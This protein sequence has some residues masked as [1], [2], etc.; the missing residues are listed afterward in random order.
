[1]FELM[2]KQ[3]KQIVN[4][5]KGEGITGKKHLRR[6]EQESARGHQTSTDATTFWLAIILNA[7]QS[8]HT[9]FHKCPFSQLHK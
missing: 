5:V 2:S 9:Y 7:I 1:M 6:P 3:E 8:S 4:R